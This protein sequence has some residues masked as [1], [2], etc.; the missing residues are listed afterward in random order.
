MSSENHLPLTFRERN[1]RYSYKTSSLGPDGRPV[2]ILHDF[3]IPV[4]KHSRY[5]DRV[6][7]YFRSSSLAVASQGFSAFTAT[8]GR[9][10]MIVGADLD[11]QDVEAILQGDDSRMAG[12]LGREI[13][14]SETWPEDVR[15]G[16]ELLAWMV[17]RGSLEVRVAFRVHG[18]T[19]KALPFESPEDGYVHEKWAVFTD[20]AGEQIAISGSLNESRRALV[21][22]AKNINL[23]A[24]WWGAS[25]RQRIDEAGTSFEQL[26][27]N[28]NPYIRVLS[29]PEAL[30]EQLIRLADGIHR[31]LEV[32]GSSAIPLETDPPSAIE[33]LRF[34][35]IQDGPM[36]PGGRFV[37]META[38]VRPWPTRKSCPG[39]SYEP[40]LTAICC[41]MRSAWL[42]QSG[43]AWLSGHYTCRGWSGVSLLRR[44]P[45]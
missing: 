16:V 42:K 10:R 38:P 27:S 37:G 8:D 1:W 43:P 41:V 18:E 21:R 33:R 23:H 30:R 32:D 39:G 35:P 36:L 17:A 2:S 26:W 19:G 22:N 13:G 7:G 31:P 44:R 4:L 5:Y 25:D 20:A 45:V 34:A 28:E 3:Y 40:G 15:R 12:V 14:Q 29:L 6:A 24:D 9:M 11:L